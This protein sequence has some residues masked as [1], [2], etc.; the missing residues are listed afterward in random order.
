[1]QFVGR[2]LPCG[3]ASLHPF[4]LLFE[5][6]PR[7]QIESLCPAFPHLCTMLVAAEVGLSAGL[8]AVGVPAL[9]LL[10]ARRGV[11]ALF[12]SEPSVVRACSGLMLPLATLLVSE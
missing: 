6:L 4:V 2:S 11:P 12:T 8:L 1:M 5:S 10:L 3:S 7:Q 9:L